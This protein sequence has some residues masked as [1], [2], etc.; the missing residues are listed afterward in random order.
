MS[1]QKEAT[2]F[3]SEE[4]KTRLKLRLLSENPCANL[5]ALTKMSERECPANAGP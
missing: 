5:P 3:T 2:V 4:R 1:G